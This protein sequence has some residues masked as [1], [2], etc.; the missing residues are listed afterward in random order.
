[1][2]LLLSGIFLRSPI[3]ILTLLDRDNFSFQLSTFVHKALRCCQCTLTLVVERSCMINMSAQKPMFLNSLL[4]SSIS[5]ALR[6]ML[7]ITVSAGNNF[8][9]FT[10][11]MSFQIFIL[12]GHLTNWTGHN[13]LTDNTLKKITQDVL[14]RCS[15]IVSDHNV[16]L[17][18]HFQNL[19]GQC[20]MTDCYFQH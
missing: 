9:L 7:L 4:F 20:P 12:V 13:L 15:V 18:G 19:V 16:K 2:L 10:G 6:T 11:H 1:M 14:V 17:A 8:F 5:L 3:Q